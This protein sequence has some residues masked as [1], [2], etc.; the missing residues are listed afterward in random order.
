MVLKAQ[1][2]SLITGIIPH[3]IT[4]GVAVLQYADGTRMCLEND[5]VKARNV[6][7]MLYIFEQMSGLKINFE[8]SEIILVGVTATLQWP[9]LKF[10]IVKLVCFL[11]N[12]LG[13]PVSPSRVRVA[14]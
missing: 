2:N 14:D 5:M 1:Q 3:M 8:K 4:N 11:L 7:L 6:K 10:L 9:M 13:V 12:I